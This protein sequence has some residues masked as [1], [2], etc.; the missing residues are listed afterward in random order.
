MNP[1]G[2]GSYN[3]GFNFGKN[4]KQ[5]RP[6]KVKNQPR[7]PSIINN[8]VLIPGP[9]AYEPRNTMQDKLIY[10]IQRGYRGQ[11]GS[12]EA[13]GKETEEDDFP[14]PASYNPQSINDERQVSSSFK[15]KIERKIID[16]KKIAP[17]VG[18]YNLIYNNI[19]TKVIKE[20]EE[21]PDLIINKPG[22]GVGE[23]RFKQPQIPDDEFQDDDIIKEIQEKHRD[24]R[25]LKNLKNNSVFKSKDPRFK[26]GKG[27][28]PGPGAYHD[29]EE[30]HWNKRTY[31]ILFADI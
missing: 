10:K 29:G 7:C 16:E 4:I 8:N 20:E 25:K 5:A 28:A 18:S 11:F 27:P 21:D 22:F 13:R 14:G 24:E 31:N 9:G 1:V 30:D 3:T 2:P 6:V 23:I 26:Q 17:P 12:T 19:A 15:S